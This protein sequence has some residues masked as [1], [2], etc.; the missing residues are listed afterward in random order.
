MRGAAERRS[1]YIYI[2]FDNVGCELTLYNMQ[3][4]LYTDFCHTLL[5]E[6]KRLR[7]IAGGFFFLL[8]LLIGISC[9]KNS[10]F[11]KIKKIAMLT[12]LL[13]DNLL[14]G[15]EKGGLCGVILAGVL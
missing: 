14:Y 13:Y 2:Y 1:L 3:A 4:R 8:R 10:V 15:A 9:R 5:G 12:R 6:I 7:R 11:E